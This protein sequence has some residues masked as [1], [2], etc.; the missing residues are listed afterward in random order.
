MASRRHT[1]LSD[2]QIDEM[3]ESILNSGQISIIAASEY[4]KRMQ[5]EGFTVETAEE[6]AIEYHAF[7]LENI[8]QQNAK[9][10]NPAYRSFLD[11]IATGIKTT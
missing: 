8:R 7:L 11:E 5:A 2:D 9:A 1:L 10:M 3:V 4:C 6:M